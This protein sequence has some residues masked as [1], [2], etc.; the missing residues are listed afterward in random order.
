[1]TNFGDGTISS[2]RIGGE[3]T[4]ELLDP[5]AATTVEGSK[6]VRDEALT[7]DGRF[8]YALD[9]DAQKVFAFEVRPDGSLDALGAADGLP[10]TVAGL[11][12]S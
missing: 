9:A 10:A 2:Y 8:L 12:A 6:G 3:G 5:I 1:V 7:G 11:A 4:I